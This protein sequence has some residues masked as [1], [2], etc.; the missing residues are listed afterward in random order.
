MTPT[1]EARPMPARENLPKLMTAPPIPMVR[2]SEAMIRQR[3]CYR[4]EEA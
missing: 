1:T 3:R 4:K 2:I